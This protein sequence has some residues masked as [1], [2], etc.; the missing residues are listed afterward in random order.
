MQERPAPKPVEPAPGTS[1][2]YWQ[3]GVLHIG[4]TEIETTYRDLQ[5]ANG[6]TVVGRVGRGEWFRVVGSEFVPRSRRATR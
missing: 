2:P 1:I 3:E 4:E 5:F 6:T